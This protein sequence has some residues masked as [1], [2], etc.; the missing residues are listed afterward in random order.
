MAFVLK[1]IDFITCCT[2]L[3]MGVSNFIIILMWFGAKYLAFWALLAS[4]WNGH[5]CFYLT[6][7][8]ENKEGFRVGEESSFLRE[9]SLCLHTGL[10][11]QGGGTVLWLVWTLLSIHSWYSWFLCF[12]CSF[13]LFPSQTAIT[14]M[15]WPFGFLWAQTSSEL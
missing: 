15:P 6:A 1:G 8:F 13:F 4:L 12:K 9:S 7:C 14:L 11:P 5:N 2:K 3:I 10:Y